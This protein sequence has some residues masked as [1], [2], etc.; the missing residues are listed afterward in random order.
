MK[1]TLTLLSRKRSQ[2][3]QSRQGYW[4]LTGTMVDS[5]TREQ[6]NRA[7]GVGCTQGNFLE[8]NAQPRFKKNA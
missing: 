1:Q 8:N 7:P 6:S 2:K 3:L 4:C 5:L